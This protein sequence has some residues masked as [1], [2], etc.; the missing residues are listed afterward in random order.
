MD[1]DDDAVPGGSILL[2]VELLVT[3]KRPSAAEMMGCC[4]TVLV[5]LSTGFLNVS[6]EGGTWSVSPA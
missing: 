1:G 3:F 5:A 6:D 4:E 2:E